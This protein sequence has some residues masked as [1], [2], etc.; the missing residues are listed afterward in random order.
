VAGPSKIHSSP[1]RRVVDF[2]LE[3]SMKSRTAR[4]RRALF[5]VTTV[6]GVM[7]PRRF[8]PGYSGNGSYS[9]KENHFKGCKKAQQPKKSV[10]SFNSF[11]NFSNR[12]QN[13]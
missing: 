4:R 3:V 12:I 5:L 13:G 6:S 8:S 10:I 7:A 2:E 11:L 1:A 9:S